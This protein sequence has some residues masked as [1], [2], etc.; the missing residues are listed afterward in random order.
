MAIRPL[1]L[2]DLP[3]IY[4]FRSEAIGLDT[5]RI[6]TRGNPLDTARLLAHMNPARHIYGAITNGES[7]PVLGGI[8]H[9][10][11]DTFAKIQYL[12]PASN[13]THPELPALIENLS[14]QAGAWGA[15]HVLAEV[16]E[17][18]GAFPPLRKSGF[19]VYAW[20]RMWNVSDAI[21]AERSAGELE[22]W[23]RARSANLPAALSLYYQIVPPLLQPIEPLPQI[24]LGWMNNDGPK[25]Y[26][27]I[28]HGAR[29]IVLTPLIHPEA[30]RVGA[31]LA[32][33][34][35]NLPD[36]RNRPVY[37]C[38]RSYQAWLEPVLADLGAKSGP[39][40][41]VMVKHL[42]RP[43]K[44]GLPAPTV[45]KGVGVQPSRVSRIEGQK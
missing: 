14:A 20:Q 36:R 33:L 6:L 41:A 12:A 23:M 15:F 18:S 2:L 35:G 1:V 7:D 3:H 19:S 16:D 28:T 44:E 21:R 39:R 29:G 37:I 24:P 43:I 26:V 17:V 4:R 27:N 40:Q 8:A 31:K 38:V 13:L 9:S 42:A 25:C 45:P 11:A 22:T 32:A 34:I 5:T 10:Q 30:N